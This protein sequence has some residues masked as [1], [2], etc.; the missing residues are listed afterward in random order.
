MHVTSPR[1]KGGVKET[2]TINIQCF[3][4]LYDFN[5]LLLFANFSCLLKRTRLECIS[6]TM[7]VALLINSGRE[8]RIA[9]FD[10]PTILTRH[11]VSI[12]LHTFH[13]CHVL[14][15][16]VMRVEVYPIK[17]ML[18]GLHVFCYLLWACAF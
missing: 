15:V 6:N 13:L 2:G 4:L 11:K 16:R 17:K 18:A 10:L 14:D 12:G 8:L 9:F 3:R 7:S 5:G 1:P